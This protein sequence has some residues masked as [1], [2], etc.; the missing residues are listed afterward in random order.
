MT[1]LEHLQDA[2]NHLSQSDICPDFIPYAKEKYLNCT[3]L[4]ELGYSVDED[5]MDEL[6]NK[7]NGIMNVPYKDEE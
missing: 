7:Y 4:L 6:I 5:D 3:I 1:I 2:N